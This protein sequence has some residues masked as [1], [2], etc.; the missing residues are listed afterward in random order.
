[1]EVAALAPD[2]IAG[3]V[4][5]GTKAE[6]RLD[7]GLHVTHA[8]DLRRMGLTA[9]WA[10]WWKPAFSVSTS[11]AIIAEAESILM[12]QPLEDVVRGRQGVPQPPKQR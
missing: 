5:I 7:S 11:S 4:L 2:R 6:R 8:N 1:M 12:R 10:E 9:A 3:L